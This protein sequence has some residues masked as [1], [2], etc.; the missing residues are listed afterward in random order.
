MLPEQYIRLKLLRKIRCTHNKPV[1]PPSPMDISRHQRTL[2]HISCQTER[3][4]MLHNKTL[5]PAH[6]DFFARLNTTTCEQ[7]IQN[8]R[9]NGLIGECIGKHKAKCKQND[10]KYF[11]FNHTRHLSLLIGQRISN[12]TVPPYS[13]VK[14]SHFPTAQ[15]M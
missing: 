9:S 3:Q 13:L 12:L 5:R 2:K 7:P 10:T 4:N 1:L 6:P 14:K 11:I 15:K 8:S